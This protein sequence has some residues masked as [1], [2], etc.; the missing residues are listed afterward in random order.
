MPSGER[1]VVVL[2]HD[3]L[4]V[5]LVVFVFFTGN[6]LCQDADTGEGNLQS[7]V[8]SW[9]FWSFGLVGWDGVF[10]VFSV[11]AGQRVVTSPL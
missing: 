3:L 8:G 5:M 6:L 7:F 10:V 11:T 1:L 2:V 9:I 4:V